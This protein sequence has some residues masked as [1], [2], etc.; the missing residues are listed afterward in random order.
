MRN[1]HKE[2]CG[3]KET[4]VKIEVVPLTV[5]YVSRFKS[6]RNPLNNNFSLT[7]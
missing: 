6:K 7:N 1:K 2:S 4:S 5:M 3:K